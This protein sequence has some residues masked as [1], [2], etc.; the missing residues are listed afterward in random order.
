MLKQVKRS[1]CSLVEVTSSSILLHLG[2]PWLELHLL[3]QGFALYEC[4]PHP[5]PRQACLSDG[6]VCATRRFLSQKTCNPSP[7]QPGTCPVA[8]WDNQAEAWIRLQESAEVAGGQSWTG[9]QYPSTHAST[10]VLSTPYVSTFKRNYSA[11][12]S[13][14]ERKIFLW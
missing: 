2:A 14:R 5:P 7:S 9:H 13:S 8:P 1:S 6:S 3:H 10:R 4:I 11:I 12:V